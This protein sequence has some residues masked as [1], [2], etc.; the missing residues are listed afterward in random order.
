MPQLEKMRK[1]D[2]SMTSDGLR[3]ILWGLFKKIV[4]ADNCAEIANQIFDNYLNLPASSLLLGAFLYHAVVCRLLGVFR[5][6]TRFC[7][8]IGI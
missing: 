1:F 8:V 3:Q 2:N 4:V 5:Y 6:G 7:K